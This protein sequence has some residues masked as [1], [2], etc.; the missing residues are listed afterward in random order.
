MEKYSFRRLIGNTNTLTLIERMLQNNTFSKFSIFEGVLGTGKSTSAR[1]AALALTCENPVN[2]NPCCKCPTCKSNIKAFETTGESASVKVVNLGKF[3]DKAEIKDLIK[4]VFVLT[5]STKSRVYIFEEAHA[6]KDVKGAQTA[7]LEEIDR[8]PK[9]TYIIMCTTRSYD[10]LEELSSRATVFT[11][12]RLNKSESEQLVV[13][14]AGTG[15]SEN[16]VRLITRNSKGIPRKIIKS[17]DFIRNNEVSEDEYVEFINEISDEVMMQLFDSMT[18]HEMKSFLDLSRML[19]DNREP[20]KVLKAAQEFMLK[21]LFTIEG[22]KETEL[23]IDVKNTVGEIFTSSSCQQ[24]IKI[25]G[26]CNSRVS[27]SELMYALFRCRL[28]LQEKTIRDVY[29]DSSKVAAVERGKAREASRVS[30]YDVNTSA[31]LTPLT[32]RIESF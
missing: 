16:L 19:L 3:D 27:E 20:V 22:A 9:N 29:A 30:D 14:E 25:L 31:K 8:M 21:V 7:F 26:Q 11:F 12:R 4:D 23:T 17:I 24:I 32:H 5:S 2:G 1:I 15:L 18:N 13:Q 10:V 28:V 6:L